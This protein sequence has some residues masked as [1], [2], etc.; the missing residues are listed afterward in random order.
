LLAD[1]RF[2]SEVPVDDQ[3]TA[4]MVDRPV[5]LLPSDWDRMAIMGL[6]WV[7]LVILL[8]IPPA[9]TRQVRNALDGRPR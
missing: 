3:A 9:V 6:P 7:G 5:E 4:A 1:I 8:V 2:L